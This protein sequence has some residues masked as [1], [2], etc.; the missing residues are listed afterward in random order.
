MWKYYNKNVKK[1]LFMHLYG[2]LRTISIDLNYKSHPC[3]FFPKKKFIIQKT[4]KTK[5]YII[6]V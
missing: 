6:S 5:T 1:S 4:L 2:I 3:T